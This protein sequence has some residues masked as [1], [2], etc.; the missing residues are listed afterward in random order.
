MISVEEAK[1]IIEH[2]IQIGKVERRSLASSVGYIV[3]KSVKSPMS[4]PPFAQ[5]AM[6]GYAF[7][8]S[9]LQST[10]Q[11]ELQ[12]VIQAGETREFVLE[13]GK[14]F[15]I[16]TGAP[17]P[18]QAD[19]VIMQEHCKVIGD[20][21]F[22]E[23]KELLA[24][25]NVRLLGSQVQAGEEFLREGVQLTPGIIGYLATLGLKDIDVYTKP[26]VNL[27]ITGSELVRV[28]E[29]LKFGQIYESNSIMLQTAL[30][31]GGI[32]VSKILYAKDELNESTHRVAEAL[33]DAD[34]VLITGGI[35]VGDYDFVQ[36]AL[37]QNG[38]EKI[39]YKLK[40][41]PGKP[42]YFGRKENTFVFALPGNPSSVLTCFYEY[43]IPALRKFCGRDFRQSSR[44]MR[45]LMH[46]YSKKGEFTHYLK[47]FATSEGV[48][49]LGAQESYKLNSFTEAN[50][51][52]MLEGERNELK[53]GELV[54]VHFLNELWKA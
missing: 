25:A 7:C 17:V 50:C 36:K 29:E 20:K 5:S 6:D 28:G 12:G 39:F 11:F 10:N 2:S 43:V 35:S 9:D 45:P 53:K 37:E 1:Q 15:R 49:I 3:A 46:E 27:L 14:C 40:Q 52:V 32:E 30:L 19:T 26:R 24:G 31:E 21:I 38:V 8:F 16:F 42:L 4:S 18:V 47:A 22:F 54:E 44:S 23:N 33:L 41:K 51:L 34:F 13:K 48:T